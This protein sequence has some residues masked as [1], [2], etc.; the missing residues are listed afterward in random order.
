MIKFMKVFIIST[1]LL[2]L[3][4]IGAIHSGTI[5]K[6]HGQVEILTLGST[7]QQV[8]YNGNYYSL[9]K[10]KLGDKVKAGQLVRT[11]IRSLAKIIFDNGDQFIISP[12]SEYMLTLP[13]SKNITSSLI[14]LTR[15]KLRA[16]IS[17][18]GP[19]NKMK[20]KTRNAAM[21]VR[22][23]D[24]YINAKGFDRSEVSVIR[25]K[26]T[27][28]VDT[29]TPK[30]VINIDTLTNKKVVEKK[31]AKEIILETGYS[32]NLVSSVNLV[33]ILQKDKTKIKAIAK[34]EIKEVIIEVK[35]TSKQKLVSIQKASKIEPTKLERES[36]IVQPK[37]TAAVA[38]KVARLEKKAIAVA[39]KDI[40]TYTP[41]LYK[42]I[43][44]RTV[45]STDQLNTEVVA[46]AH[47]EAPKAIKP[48]IDDLD[49]EELSEDVY[50]EYFNQH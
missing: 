14:N 3:S 25:G 26:V 23:T 37:V 45:K 48:D 39:L 49:N 5:S 33:N 27:L 30:K 11:G 50:Q 7:G 17:K 16:I 41:N 28:K 6:I 24:F 20:V 43:I 4:L 32:A 22:G 46:A 13:K 19:R 38:K 9:I 42:K 10:A 15:G 8:K 29:K 31:V 44:A 18:H 47:K 2:P 21:G 35:R 36:E 34:K 40:E 12:G 1:L